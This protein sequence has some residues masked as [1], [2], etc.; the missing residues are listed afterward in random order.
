M[1]NMMR[2]ARLFYLG[3]PLSFFAAFF[4]GNV[5]VH[6]Q[7]VSSPVAVITWSA[8][9]SYVPPAY[10]GKKLPTN[11]STITAS[12]T[13]F[14]KGRVANLTGN[15]I[16]WYF[17]DTLLG[18]GLGARSTS[19]I[20]F[21]SNGDSGKL[22]VQIPDY[23]GGLVIKTIP[24]SVVSPVAVIKTLYPAAAFSDN[25]LVVFAEPYFFP[26]S[27]AS[28][29]SYR[30]SVNDK[31]VSSAEDPDILK[32]S[33][34]PGTVAGSRFDVLLSVAAGNSTAVTDEKT[35]VYQPLP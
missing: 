27:S 29:L 35:L 21:I 5:V 2:T 17:N 16:Y 28:Q 10:V 1:N 3:I 8:S 26:V 9:G 34:G 22:K 32:V 15:T 11:A 24:I 18:G 31:A 19:F 4:G 14:D 13:V 25:P 33:L 20:P 12:V 6:A 30:W 7:Q 23:A